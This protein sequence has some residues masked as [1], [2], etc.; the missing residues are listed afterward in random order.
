MPSPQVLT[1]AEDRGLSAAHAVT[2]DIPFHW[3]AEDAMRFLAV[4][5]HG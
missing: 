3:D 2:L 1:R 4:R 5:A